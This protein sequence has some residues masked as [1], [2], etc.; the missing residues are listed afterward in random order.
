MIHTQQG[1]GQLLD[2]QVEGEM[3]EFGVGVAEP[4]ELLKVD[5]EG[6][7]I[8]ELHLGQRDQRPPGEEIDHTAL[9][10]ATRFLVP[11]LLQGST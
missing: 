4:L 2:D 3:I 9:F 7:Y 10:D 11:Q 6:E 8:F 1:I 5:P